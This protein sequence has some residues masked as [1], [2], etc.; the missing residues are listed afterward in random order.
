[1]PTEFT[2]DACKILFDAN[3]DHDLQI[4]NAHLLKKSLQTVRHLAFEKKRL[5][6]S[7]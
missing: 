2:K 1:M 4:I 7:K 6:I 5:V 3:G